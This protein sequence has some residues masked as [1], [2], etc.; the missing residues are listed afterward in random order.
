MEPSEVGHVLTG[1]RFKK[2][3]GKDFKGEAEVKRQL[4][5]ARSEKRALEEEINY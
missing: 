1:K 4:G 5:I 3:I 2:I